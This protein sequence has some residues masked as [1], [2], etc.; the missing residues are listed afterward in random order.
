MLADLLRSSVRA[1]KALWN[2]H[3]T[4]R[5]ARADLCT[6]LDLHG[7]ASDSEVLARVEP[8]VDS[9]AAQPE[10][11]AVEAMLRLGGDVYLD[12]EG[13]HYIGG[14]GTWCYPSWS[15]LA[16]HVLHGDDDEDHPN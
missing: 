14:D 8:L 12:E 15:A 6:L 16:R 9:S 13:C 3:L 5:E 1:A 4:E 7:N 2:Y 10:L 11:D